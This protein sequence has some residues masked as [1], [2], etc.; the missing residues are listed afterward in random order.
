MGTLKKD[1]INNN[2]NNQ[3]LVLKIIGATFELKNRIGYRDSMK[4]SITTAT[5][6]GVF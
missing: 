1:K 4:V 3:C 6:G 2:N 5:D